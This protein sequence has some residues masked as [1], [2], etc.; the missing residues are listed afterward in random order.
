[1]YVIDW[2]DVGECHD[3]NVTDREHGRIFRI[4]Y[5]GAKGGAGA[6]AA[7][8]TPHAAVD[9]S[10]Y[11]NE[12]LVD[13]QTWDNEWYVRHARRCCAT[14]GS[15]KRTSGSWARCYEG[16]TNP[17]H[18]L[19][20]MWALHACGGVGEDR[21]LKALSDPDEYLRSW[22]VQLLAEDRNPSGAA[23]ERFKEMAEA[24][25]SPVVRLYLAA[26]MQRT[27]SAQRAA[28]LGGLL[29]H[30]ED[31]ADPNLPAMDWYALEPLAGA[32]PQGAA[33][34]LSKS[35]I[36]LVREL[37]ARRVAAERSDVAG[38][39]AGRAG[40]P[41]AAALDVLRGIELGLKDKRS[42]PAPAGWAEASRRLT[43]SPDAAVRELA[44]SLSKKF[45]AAATP[46]ALLAKASDAKADRSERLDAVESLLEGR[47]PGLAPLLRRLVAE[48]G[49][50]GACRGAAIRGLAGYDD[51][52][53]PADLLKVYA[54]LGP[55]EK[56]DALNALASRRPFAAALLAAFK[57]GSIPRSDLKAHA[58]QLLE[59]LG[60]PEVD[61]WLA[62]NWGAARPTD[63]EKR[64]EIARVAAV[65]NDAAPGESR[66]SR[67]R[68]LFTRTCAA[69]HTLFGEGG[70]VGPDLTG[71]QRGN[72]NF[73]LTSIVDPSAVVPQEY[74][75][76][77]ARTKDG[78][79][80]SGIVAR[81]DEQ[82]VTFVNA[83]E[84][85]VI[86]RAEIDRMRPTATSLMP[87]GLLAGM[88]RQDVL[89]LIAYL[90]GTPEAPGG[91]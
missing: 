34:W 17:V 22:A 11:L 81:P 91:R 45:G 80:V 5:A 82:S 8:A 27:P 30:A 39:R 15:A 16:A 53:I 24:D 7:K 9:L 4:A 74:Q 57:A 28:V 32:D 86:P 79:T 72:L 85:L 52:Q 90:R 29:G 61:R 64:K 63:A 10:A 1:M 62:E 71:T 67:G 48:P 35:K 33:A 37:I 44:R 12:K 83:G 43:A 70:K 6:A 60:D 89:D 49:T 13:M 77:V 20:A 14:A 55:A 84:T 19:R 25:A 46:E 2:S 41:G 88:P 68:A 54:A 69:C 51:P 31:A 75:V 58:V 42:V 73:L 87:E 59:G 3:V 65:I 26:A 38:G 66:A 36:P 40:G 21:L 18:R 47:T 78:R 56:Q 50:G 76:W 23:L